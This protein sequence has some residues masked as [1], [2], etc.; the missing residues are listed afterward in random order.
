[1]IPFL[2]VIAT[3]GAMSSVARLVIAYLDFQYRWR[4]LPAHYYGKKGRG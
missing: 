4:H 2:A 1:M 3:I